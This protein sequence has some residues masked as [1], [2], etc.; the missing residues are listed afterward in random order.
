MIN[1]L[2]I[3]QQQLAKGFFTIGS[4]P[5]VILVMGSCRVIN[6]V[7]YLSEW[8]EANGNRFT[9][10]SIDPFSWNWDE[11]EERTDYAKVLLELE[12]H[13][14][15]LSMLKSVDILIHEYYANAGMFNC[16]VP[17]DKNIYQFGMNPQIDICLP[18]FNDCF[19]LF[20]DLVS[21][22]ADLRK[23]AI[24][25]YN[26]IGKLSEQTK[27]EIFKKSQF[28]IEKFY[29]V[30]RGSD[31]PEM[32]DYFAENFK[33]QRLFWTYNHTSKWFTL[34]IFNFI[35]GKFLHLDLSNGFNKD[36]EDMFANN[37]TKLTEYD[38]EMYGYDWGEE[39]IPLKDKLF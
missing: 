15:L 18:N 24:A 38:I 22:D 20:S 12:H 33:K 9:I 5:E 39:I 26:V 21:F 29:Y 2:Q 10:H 3:K 34:A 16:K 19:I 13:E 27:D 30:C 11:K 28:G 4:G 31:V 37:Y 35:N 1:T 14:G 6:F 7:T 32:Q 17:S 8:N 25:D 36:H 23:K